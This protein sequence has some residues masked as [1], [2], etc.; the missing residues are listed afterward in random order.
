MIRF[1]FTI[2]LVLFMLSCSQNQSASSTKSDSAQM[3]KADTLNYAYKAAYSSSFDIAKPENAKTVLA[4]WKSYEDNKLAD[5]KSL[6]ADSVTLE[7]EDFT[8]RGPRDSVVAGGIRD[9][10]QYTS[11]VDSVDAWIPLHSNDKNADWVAV[12]AREYT[13]DKKGKKDTADIHEV[14]LLRDGKVAYMSQ[15]RAHRKH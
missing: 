6:W 10:S 14:W 4:I 15:F 1:L 13:T 3:A 8:F 11:L 2:V 9:R 7:F 12:W 5:T